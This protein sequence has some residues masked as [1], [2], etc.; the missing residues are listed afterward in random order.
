MY[1]MK[2]IGGGHTRHDNFASHLLQT[3]SSNIYLLS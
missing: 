2:V 3:L 1:G